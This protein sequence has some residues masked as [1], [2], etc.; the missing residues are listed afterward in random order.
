MTAAPSAD[1]ARPAH[2]Q[3]AAPVTQAHAT[4]P[5]HDTVVDPAD[6]PTVPIPRDLI[7]ALDTRRPTTDDPAGDRLDERPEAVSVWTTAQASPVTQRKNK[8]VP[9]STAHPA[10]MLPEVARHAVTHYTRPGDLVL[11][12]MCGIGTTLVEAVRLGRRAVGVEYEPHWV[13]VAKANLEVARDDGFTSDA[14]VFHGDA[15]QLVTLLPPE[16]V[17]QAAL[18][19]TSPPYGPSTHGQVLVAPGEGVQKYHH[20]YGNT[21]DRG[22]LANIGH[23]R[24]LAGFTRILFGLR[25]FLRPGGHIAITIRPWREHAELIDLPAQIL[26]CGVAAGLIPVERNVALLARAA[27]TDFVARGSFFQR[28]FIRK[29]REAG[30]PLHLIAHED[31]LVFRTA[32]TTT[33]TDATDDGPARSAPAGEASTGT[34]PRWA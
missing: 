5:A 8:Y 13:D 10:K 9:A 22:N 33:D 29:Q 12:P 2:H 32:L 7:N 21:L 34:E 28:D 4:P 1:A 3:E 11:D 25:T 6:E 16:Y 27:E 26:A 20:R 18:V 31:V 19:V 17:G 24:L 30:L 14:R 23:H 15:R